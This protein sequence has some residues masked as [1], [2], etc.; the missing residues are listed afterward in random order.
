M[1]IID[2]ERF[3]NPGA[4]WLFFGY[5]WAPRAPAP[6]STPVSRFYFSQAT[7]APA[8][9]AFGAWG[10]TGS[11]LRKALLSEKDAGETLSQLQ[12]SA[13]N[14]GLWLQLVSPP[15]AAQTISG[16]FKVQARA[17]DVNGSGDMRCRM[18]I[19]AVSDDGMSDL[20]V[21]AIGNYG[22]N[23]FV[24]ATNRNKTFANG[25]TSITDFTVGDDVPVGPGVPLGSRLVIELGFSNP[26]GDVISLDY[27]APS[28]ASDLPENETETGALVPWIEFSNAILLQ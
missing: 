12:A 3:D 23:T 9:P 24:S 8:S 25:S 11:A 18:A 15:L 26:S 10:N 17:K 22:P 13:A 2:D 20:T 16:T 7:A 6:S 19:R 1:P 14:P 21:I 27:G 5:I 4:A 28:S